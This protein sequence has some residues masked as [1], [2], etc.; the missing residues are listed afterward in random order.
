MNIP[1][2]AS[3]PRS[4]KL[5]YKVT[6]SGALRINQGRFMSRYTG[7]EKYAV[8]IN[9]E[10]KEAKELK[11]ELAASRKDK[12]PKKKAAPVETGAMPNDLTIFTEQIS[13]NLSTLQPELPTDTPELS[14]EK[15]R[16]YKIH[17]KKVRERI[18]NFVNTRYGHYE[19]YL[20]TISFPKDTPDAICF[21]AL[22]TWLTTQRMK[23]RLH[24][25][26][27]I[28][29]RQPNTNTV[30]FHIAVPHY[31][32]VQRAN[33][34][35]K[36]TLINLCKD[37]KM[38]CTARFIGEKYNGVDI[39]KRK[40]RHG[41]KRITNFAEKRGSKALSNYLSKYVSK[42]DAEFEHLAWH[43]SR[44]FSC[45]FT[46]CALTEADFE[47]RHQFHLYLNQFR[48]L[49]SEWAVWGP[50]AKGPP[51]KLTA[52]L[53]EINSYVQFI[54]GIIHP[55]D[56]GGKLKYKK[57]N[58]NK[59]SKKIQFMRYETPD[60]FISLTE[61]NASILDNERRMIKAFL[62]F[63]GEEDF[64]KEFSDKMRVLIRKRVTELGMLR[65]FNGLLLLLDKEHADKNFWYTY[66]LYTYWAID[67]LN[68]IP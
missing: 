46:G 16:F 7:N 51:E 9:G 59:S 23:N 19:L 25:Y 40:D 54:Q 36:V 48:V 22:Q 31:M 18:Q 64:N 38:P 53:Y 67:L 63:A 6:L 43:N 17:K 34:A 47:D 52:A 1:T 35:M 30:H 29:E 65:E 60:R 50:W 14:T 12:R 39:Q 8:D 58:T 66:H 20:W 11:K 28:A 2:F 4:E 26:I 33:R 45:L 32:D 61:A 62:L 37:G 55:F 15:P 27:W 57:E 56:K 3:V 13:E 41:N 49:V 42:N 10:L 68:Q 24:E 5:D 44:A 21:Q